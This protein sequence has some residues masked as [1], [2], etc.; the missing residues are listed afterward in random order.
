MATALTARATIEGT[1]TALDQGT[2]FDQGTASDQVATVEVASGSPPARGLLGDAL[3]TS[4][5]N[6][7]DTQRLVRARRPSRA[8][9]AATRSHV[10]SLDGLRGVAVVLV[11]AFHLGLSWASGGF[12]G[13]DV[14][15]VLSGYLI[16]SLLVAEQRTS[17][18]VDLRR[19]W[20]RRARRLLPA[21]CLLL[22]VLAV[23]SLADPRL[24]SPTALRVDGLATLFYV[25]NWHLA[26]QSHTAQLAQV[27]APSPLLHTW[28]LAIE[29]QYY[30]LW[31]FVV[32]LA[33]RRRRGT[34]GGRHRL[35]LAVL[36]GT[37]A[38]I[39]ASAAMALAGWAPL[40]IY[41]D[42]GARAFELLVGAGLALLAPLPDAD[43]AS[44]RHRAAQTTGARPSPANAASGWEAGP[45][46]AVPVLAR[47]PL[48]EALAVRA[49]GDRRSWRHQLR[50]TDTS[51]G[52]V[53]AL[54][55]GVGI[56]GL[57]GIVAFAASVPGIGATW[58]YQGGLFAVCLVAAAV[59]WAAARFPTTGIGRL[60]CWRPVVALGRI[61]YGVYL[62]HW[63]VLVTVT[64]GSTGLRG[65]PLLVLQLGLTLLAAMVSAALVERPVRRWRPAVALRRLVAPVALTAGTC[66]I[67]GALAGRPPV[68]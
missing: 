28:S 58:L 49:A 22:V 42:S 10:A 7:P 9:G 24:V 18:W 45:S 43:P 68:P 6:R 27:F 21:L 13:V 63:P 59:V 38:S 40:T 53:R 26:L 56:A 66:V 50:R 31:P 60:L 54:A 57:G 11:V 32:A 67:V 65:A 51:D 61:S 30:L 14:F 1:G 35:W 23:V 17:G 33:L 16:T 29:E 15:F 46:P 20:G 44:H 25:Q 36:V 2:A 4:P 5:L 48:A 41:Y 12:V 55:T 34:P 62:W 8:V 47:A 37:V 52:W 19:F 3:A 39:A 64:T